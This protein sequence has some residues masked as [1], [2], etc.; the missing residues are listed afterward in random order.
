MSLL[1]GFLRTGTVDPVE[2][3]AR[4][5]AEARRRERPAHYRAVL[6]AEAAAELGR[7][8]DYERQIETLTAEMAHAEPWRARRLQIEIDDLYARAD[9]R[10]SRVELIDEQRKAAG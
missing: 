10:R 4:A 2:A 8:A 7:V 5:I 6:D 9:R 3:E 1:G